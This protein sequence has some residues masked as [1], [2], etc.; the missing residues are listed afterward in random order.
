MLCGTAAG[1]RGRQRAHFFVSLC[2]LAEIEIDYCHCNP[3]LE[4]NCRDFS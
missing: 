3:L 4:F 2:I 1:E